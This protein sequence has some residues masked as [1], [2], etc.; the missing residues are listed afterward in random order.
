MTTPPSEILGRFVDDYGNAF[1][2]SV[3]RFDQ[4]PRGRFDI[5]EWHLEERYFI[6]RNDAANP[7]DGGLWT[8][9]DWMPF[10]GME[11]YTWGFCLTAYRAPNVREARQTSA[12]NRDTPRTGCNGFPFSRMRR[13]PT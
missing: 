11:P 13:A 7:R 5:V 4:L 8:R 2:L 6:A 3:Q 10:T 12:P 1:A 9:V